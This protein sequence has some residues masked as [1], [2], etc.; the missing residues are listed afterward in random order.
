MPKVKKVSRSKEAAI[1]NA[2]RAK[3]GAHAATTPALEKAKAEM[4]EYI[5]TGINV[6]DRYVLK[7]G[8]LPIG[9]YSEVFGG[10]G[11]GKTSL[12]YA[13]L[14]GVQRM[15][16]VAV[17][18]DMEQ[19]FDEERAQVFGVD[20]ESLIVIDHA[21]N[22]DMAIE[23]MKDV[24]KAHDPDDGPLGIGF[25][26]IAASKTKVAM[27]M[28][29]GKKQPA[30]EAAMLSEELP[31]ILPLLSSHRAHL[32]L[33][34][35]TRTKLGI[36][37]G[38]PETT[39]GGNAPKFYSSVRLSFMGGKKIVNALDEHIGKTVTITGVKNRLAPPFRKARVRL[40]YA[41]GWNEVASTLEHAKTMK[42][43]DPREKGFKGKGKDGLE[44]YIEACERLDWPCDEVKAKATIAYSKGTEDAAGA[45]EDTD[46]D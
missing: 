16:G 42:V 6:L 15:G 35:Q 43:I 31:K 13:F 20:T 26:S 10:E 44:A 24:L 17:D 30:R 3:W 29:A 5:P 33:L 1:I 38:N 23:Q 9:R 45:D 39:P 11:C 19:S 46:E 12:M 2:I 18:V 14:A 8:G 21:E 25:D 37:F 36:M 32:M 34:N 27:D 40:D 41:H 28:E 22:M 4:T 7:R